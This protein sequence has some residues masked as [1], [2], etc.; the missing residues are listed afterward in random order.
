MCR[1]RPGRF[2]CCNSWV[3]M[4]LSGIVNLGE[5]AFFLSLMIKSAQADE[6]NGLIL[7]WILGITV[8]R[9]I[10]WAI[11]C[12]DSLRH[13]KFYATILMLTTIGEA[14]FYVVNQII[15]FTEDQTYCNRVYVMYYMMT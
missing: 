8:P 7:I 5:F 2:L 1:G 15:I 6:F 10:F 13:R 11:M 3:G 9:I 14:I 12:A 4:H